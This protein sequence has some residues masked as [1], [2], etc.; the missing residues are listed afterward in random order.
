VVRWWPAGAVRGPSV[1]FC[2]RYDAIDDKPIKPSD[3]YKVSKRISEFDSKQLLS[4]YSSSNKLYF[5]FS[6]C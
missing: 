1:P 5:L 4:H 2:S 3:S 6:S